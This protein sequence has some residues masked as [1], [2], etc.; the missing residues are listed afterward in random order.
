M[1]TLTVFTP[2][3]NR[4]YC[5]GELYNSLLRQENKDFK[6]LI[7]DDGSS[8]GTDQLVAKWQNEG[9]IEILYHYKPNG[10]MHTAH[11]AAYELLDTEL[12]MCIDSDDYLTDDAV[13]KILVF[14]D[15]NKAENVG[16]IYALDAT[17]DGKILGEKYPEDMKSFQGWGCKVVVYNDGK[18]HKV[19]GDKKCIAVTKYLKKYPPI[20]VFEGEKFY[21][22]YWKQHFL[23]RDYQILILNEPVCIVEYLPDGASM[24]KFKQYFTNAKGF[25]HMRLILMK[26][27]PT[28][29]LRFVEC[30]HY[31]NSSIILKDWTFLSKSTNKLLTFLAIP[32]G[33]L[34]HLYVKRNYNKQLQLNK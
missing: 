5:L 21:S 31:I 10:G 33:I 25:Q 12:N 7:I 6:W 34:L 9:K 13:A 18:I 15:Q 24:N 19:V 4:A 8:D 23:E 22:L 28:L 17:K 27:S 32:F 2:T 14:W 30:M 1:K 26:D 3:F 29:K 16:A 20:P 11:N